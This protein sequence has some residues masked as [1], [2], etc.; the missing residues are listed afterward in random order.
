MPLISEFRTIAITLPASLNSA[1]N[2]TGGSNQ[3][4]ASCIARAIPKVIVFVHPAHGNLKVGS[5]VIVFVLKTDEF[6]L[7]VAQR[8]LN[9][10]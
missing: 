2:E 4:L 8:N 6:S 9:V 7:F 10:P 1:P 3:N 5:K